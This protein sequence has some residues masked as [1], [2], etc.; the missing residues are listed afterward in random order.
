MSEKKET[1]KEQP[2]VTPT[3][4]PPPR[5]RPNYPTNDGGE[6]KSWDANV[7]KEKR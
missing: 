1:P 5:E 6:K 4:P 2:K 3:P 7:G